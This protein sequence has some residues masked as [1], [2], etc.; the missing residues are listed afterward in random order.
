M[1]LE[2]LLIHNLFVFDGDHYLQKCGASMGAKFSPSLANLYM[3]WWEKFRIF[4]P[5]SPCQ[6]DTVFYCRYINDLLFVVSGQHISL[7]VWLHYMNDNQLNLRFTGH[8]DMVSIEFF[9][10]DVV[11]TED[12]DRI[13][14]NL[15]RKPTAGNTLLRTDFSPPGHTIKS[16]PVGQFLRL[17][18]LCSKD[19]DF[20][21]EAIHMASRF[22]ARRYPKS[23]INRAFNIAP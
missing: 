7:D 3:G 19:V 9:L 12:G 4:G 1:S 15:Y 17:K 13:T 18:R 23:V 14:S 11:L 6:K 2:Y 10:L 16:I 21:Q 20:K 8:H 5:D 22:E